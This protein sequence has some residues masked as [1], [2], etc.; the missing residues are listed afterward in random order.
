MKKALFV[1]IVCIALVVISCGCTEQSNFFGS[2]N[3]VTL[4]THTR[5]FDFSTGQIITQEETTEDIDVLAIKNDNKA[6]LKACNDAGIKLPDED[7]YGYYVEVPV[8]GKCYVKDSEGGI[9]TVTVTGIGKTED[10][11]PTATITWSY[12]PGS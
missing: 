6:T 10:D 9:A 3:T 2:G 8:G 12:A 7:E 11:L 1:I 5:M 4:I